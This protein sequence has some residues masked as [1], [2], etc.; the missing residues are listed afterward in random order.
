MLTDGRQLE[1]LVGE[2]HHPERLC[3]NERGRKRGERGLEMGPERCHRGGRLC[4]DSERI[5]E[6]EINESERLNVRGAALA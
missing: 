6:R 2:L 4:T 3:T 5:W 1:A